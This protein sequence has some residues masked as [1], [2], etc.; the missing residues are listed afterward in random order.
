VTYA[1]SVHF[2]EPRCRASHSHK[3]DPWA[4]ISATR[5]VKC[6]Q[7]AKPRFQKCKG[8]KRALAICT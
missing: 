5:N 2:F 6:C 3:A 8:W 4:G 7:Q 1:Y